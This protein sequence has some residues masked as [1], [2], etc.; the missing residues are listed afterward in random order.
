[1]RIGLSITDPDRKFAFPLA[2]YERQDAE[3]DAAYYRELIE[4][5]EIAGLVIGLPLHL[6]GREGDKAREARVFAAWLGNV[7]ALPIVFWDE[8]FTTVEAESALWMAGLTHK[9]RKG[10]RDRVAAQIML[11]AYLDAGCPPNPVVGSLDE[12]SGLQ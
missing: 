8:R 12:P 7:V 2:T 9:K 10:K 1:V 11:Q 6:D 5:E 3:K 4:K